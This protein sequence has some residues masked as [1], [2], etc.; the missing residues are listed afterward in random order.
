V[1]IKVE[2]K[3]TIVLE[4]IAEELSKECYVNIM[5]QYRPC[6]EAHEYE[7]LNRRPTSI[8]YLKVIDYA[9]ELGLHRGFSE[10]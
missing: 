7:E 9:S 10:H 2:F 5:A 1:D 4:F 6:G 3:P 8:E